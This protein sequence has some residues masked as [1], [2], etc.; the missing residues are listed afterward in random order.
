MEFVDKLLNS[1]GKSSMSASDPFARL[2]VP[3]SPSPTPTRDRMRR[4]SCREAIDFAI[5]RG[6]GQHAGTKGK[7]GI[8]EIGKDGVTVAKLTLPRTTYKL[9]EVVEGIVEFDD[10]PMMCYQVGNL[11]IYL[12]S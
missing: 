9:G 6:V 8:F 3:R 7:I 11:I 4:L 12:I 10:S 1:L 2:S 5:Q